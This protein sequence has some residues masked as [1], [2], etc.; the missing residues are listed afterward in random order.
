V[1]NWDGESVTI[2]DLDTH[3]ASEPI[4]TDG[5]PECGHYSP[6]FDRYYVAGAPTD[7]LAVIDGD[8]DSIVMHVS[9]GEHVGTV[10]TVTAVPSHGVVMAGKWNDSGWDEDT[11]FVADA[12][13]GALVHR[14]AMARAPE[15]LFYSSHSDRLYAAC[16]VADSVTVFGGDGSHV[17]GT[18]PV[19]QWPFVFAYSTAHNR[20]YVGH[21][22]CGWVYVVRDTVMGVEERL[23]STNTGAVIACRPNPFHSRV[24]LRAGLM[25][26]AIV[27]YAT[28]GRLV[29]E[30]SASGPGH[31]ASSVVWDGRDANGVLVPAGMYVVIEKG[32]GGARA[33][34]V[35]Q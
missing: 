26:K 6:V 17:V 5:I 23:A 4:D 24:Q 16:A 19:G 29:R 33:L 8:A 3:Q 32:G 14:T 31:E 27:V 35:K 1:R 28:D 22:N 30:I 13:T 9:V 25:A 18:L 12:L 2:I 34:L 15:D 7:S 21:L 11:L 20:L 10:K